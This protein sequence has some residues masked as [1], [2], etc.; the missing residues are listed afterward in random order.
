M[1]VMVVEADVVIF[2]F[3]PLNSYPL[4][5]QFKITLEYINSIFFSEIGAAGN[6]L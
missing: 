1:K 3:F 2:C 5:L 6:A 4:L